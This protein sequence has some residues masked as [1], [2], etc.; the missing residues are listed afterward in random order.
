MHGRVA[1]C[2]G[3]GYLFAEKN[4]AIMKVPGSSLEILVLGTDGLRAGPRLC[5]GA[6]RGVLLLYCGHDR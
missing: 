6:V 2:H 5:Q 1:G 4:F 3:I